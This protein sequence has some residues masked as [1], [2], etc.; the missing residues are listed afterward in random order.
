MG[1]GLGYKVD[2]ETTLTGDV[3]T[4]DPCMAIALAQLTNFYRRYA[5][6]IQKLHHRPHFTTGG[7]WNKSL[8]LQP[9]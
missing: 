3:L 7:S 9:L 5:L 6:C 2:D 1:G 8:Y 4:V